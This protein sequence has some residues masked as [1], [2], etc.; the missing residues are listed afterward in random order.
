MAVIR[1]RKEI[2]RILQKQ[3]IFLMKTLSVESNKG[4]LMSF[5]LVA[6]RLRLT[7]QIFKN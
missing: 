3:K 2:I 1:K 7:Q 4:D 5:V 6:G